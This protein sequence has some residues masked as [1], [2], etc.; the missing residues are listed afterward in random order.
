MILLLIAAAFI[1]GMLI[2]HFYVHDFIANL[3]QKIKDKL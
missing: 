2:E 1:G 3:K